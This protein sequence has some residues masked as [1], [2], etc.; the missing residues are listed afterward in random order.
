MNTITLP[1][2]GEINI[3]K[4]EVSYSSQ[5]D[6]SNAVKLDIHLWDKTIDIESLE[7]I[8]IVIENIANYDRLNK[9]YLLQEYQTGNNTKE[10]LEFHLSQIPALG[11]CFIEDK[12]NEAEPIFH[13]FA[14]LYL[15]KVWF[16]VYANKEIQ[17]IFDYSVGVDVTQYKL[18]IKRKL[19]G[20]FSEI[21]MES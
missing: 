3:E 2:V 13:A 10:Y 15:Y 18:V 8:K 1:Y 14:K 5:I 7:K 11:E 19:N 9:A 16:S 6:L 12:N 21:T 17:I 20:A 4:L